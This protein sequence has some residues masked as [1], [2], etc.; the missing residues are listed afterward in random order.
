MTMSRRSAYHAFLS[1]SPLRGT[2]PQ[3]IQLYYQRYDFY[4]RPPCGGRLSA[5]FIAF[6]SC[7]FL[8]TSPLRGT[9]GGHPVQ[10]DR[11]Q[12]FYPR[13]PCGGRPAPCRRRSP[14]ACHFYPR[15]PCGGRPTMPTP[16]TAASKFLSTSPLRGTTHAMHWDR[17]GN[18]DFYPRPPC[19]GRQALLIYDGSSVKIS[20]HVPLAGDD[21]FGP[22]F[23]LRRG[24]FL[25]TSPL[26]GTTGE[27][28][29]GNRL[30]GIS[31]HVPLAG[32][33]PVLPAGGQRAC[34]FYPRPPCGGRPITFATPSVASA[35][36]YPRPPCGGRPGRCAQAG[37]RR[38]ISIHVPLAG[39]DFGHHPH[40]A[41][42][43]ISIH[44]PLAGD[45]TLYSVRHQY[46][47]TFLST[48][49][50]RGTTELRHLQR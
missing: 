45:D 12:H 23:S 32:D 40:V 10:G 30:Y 13:P 18:T 39:D 3:V 22:L 33:D 46:F 21:I 44:V 17:G 9:T 36:F 35:D 6:S 2:T 38:D 24:K 49:P 11:P 7:T 19:G 27:Q 47:S 29:R 28:D 42:S 14:A 4:P 16:H 26:R 20:I 37:A 34:H 48:S 5:L 1:T 50:L 8:S 43:N 25:S 15:P 41:V 31:I